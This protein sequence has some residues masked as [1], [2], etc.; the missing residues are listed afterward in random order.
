MNN[1]YNI[2]SNVRSHFLFSIIIGL[3][4]ACFLYFTEPFE[5]WRFKGKT[6]LIL[7]SGFGFIAVLSYGLTFLY[8]KTIQKR[9]IWKIK[10]ELIFTLL[11]STVGFLLYYSFYYVMVPHYTKA[12]PVFIYFKLIYSRALLIIL[13]IVVIGR[14]FLVIKPQIEDKKI[15]IAGTGKKEF[16]NLYFHQIMYIKSA[17][18]YVEVYYKENEIIQ[19]KMIRKTFKSTIEELPKMLRTHR[20]F[21]INPSYFK[22]FA[23]EKNLIS[24]ILENDIEIP[25]SNTYKKEVEAL[26]IRHK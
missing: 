2:S 15:T 12:Y 7:V 23:K 22:S 25:I 17:D 18:N 6:K 16:A 3:W 14:Y 5:L 13:P 8:Q 20:S 11:I 4:V 9:E 21:L 10:N 26:L 24:A 19:K 1:E